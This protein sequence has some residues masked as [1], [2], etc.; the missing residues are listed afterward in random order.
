VA[1]AF[2]T[3]AVAAP[4]AARETAP[5]PPAFEHVHALAFDAG[6][7]VL[8]L[9]AHTGLYRSEDGGSSLSR[10]AKKL[11]HRALSYASPT[12]P[13]DGRTPASRHRLPKAT[14]V[15]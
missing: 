11:S 10:V 3:A 14:D 7:R 6:G 5:A 2:G 15:Y 8:W 9:G 4:V 12:L 1:V 13:I